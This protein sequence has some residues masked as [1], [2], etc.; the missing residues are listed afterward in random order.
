MNVSFLL[1]LFLS[2]SYSYIHHRDTHD[3]REKGEWAYVL[4]CACARACTYVYTRALYRG[5]RRGSKDPREL[6][7]RRAHIER[8]ASHF[9]FE[10]ACSG[11]GPSPLRK[12]NERVRARGRCNE[13]RRTMKPR[14]RGYPSPPSPSEHSGLYGERERRN[15]G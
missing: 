7:K 2:I 13:P 10:S 15:A 1:V 9:S 4:L 5:G 3:P 12:E 6:H 8:A 14:W 11:A